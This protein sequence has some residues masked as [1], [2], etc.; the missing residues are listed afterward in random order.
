MASIHSKVDGIASLLSSLIPRLSD[1][2]LPAATGSDSGELNV[3]VEDVVQ[4]DIRIQS[5]PVRREEPCASYPAR[6][7]HH[8]SHGFAP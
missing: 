5:E 1:G 8:T 7:E 2:A 4:A 6:S 3:L